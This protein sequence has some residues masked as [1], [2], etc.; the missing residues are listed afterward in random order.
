[1]QVDESLQSKH[2]AFVNKRFVVSGIFEN[3][4]REAIKTEIEQ[5]GGVMASSVSA[6]TDFLIAGQGMGPSKR[7]KALQLNIP[8]LSEQDYI[9]LKSS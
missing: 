9:A 8:I 2:P 4:E 7:E 3:F 6:K 5:L 1:M